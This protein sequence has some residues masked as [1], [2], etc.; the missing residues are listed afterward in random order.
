MGRRVMGGSFRVAGR[1]RQVLAGRGLNEWSSFVVLKFE[2]ILFK[3]YRIR[4]TLRGQDFITVFTVTMYLK[5]QYLFA[6]LS[7]LSCLG[8]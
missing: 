4:E 6:C 2:V 8:T 7:I 5:V 1:I 3:D